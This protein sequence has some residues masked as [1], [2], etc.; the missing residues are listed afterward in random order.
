LV[1][2]LIFA[3]M[4][5]RLD[6]LVLLLDT[7]STASVRSAAAKQ[8]GDVQKQHPADLYNLLQRILIHLHSKTWETRVA[9]G[10][11]IKAIAENVPLW[12]PPPGSQTIPVEDESLSFASF[13]ISQVID[14]GEP[15]VASAGKE[16]DVD[17]SGMDPKERLKMQ[18][19]RLKERLG[20][21]TQF[22]DVDFF[23]EQDINVLAQVK[24]KEE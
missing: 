23:D 21:G 15:L 17:L 7:G 2:E 12:D 1:L 6:R 24:V 10:L 9:A 11:A 22:M 5:T 20:L 16:F 19:K 14:R 3:Q 4:S 8:L 18:K 13:N